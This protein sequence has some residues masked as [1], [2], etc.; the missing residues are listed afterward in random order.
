MG[1]KWRWFGVALVASGTGLIAAA[2]SPNGEEVGSGQQPAPAEITTDEFVQRA[3]AVCMPNVPPVPNL[4][5]YGMDIVTGRF[6]PRRINTSRSRS[7]VSLKIG[8][9]TSTSTI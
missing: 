8:T 4:A 5:S 1:R 2:C 6:R 7:T 9:R 3:D